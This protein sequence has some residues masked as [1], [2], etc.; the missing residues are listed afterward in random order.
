MT[1]KLCILATASLLALAIPAIGFLQDPN[2]VVKACIK[3]SDRIDGSQSGSAPARCRCFD[4]ASRRF[5]DD[6]NYA[7]LEAASRRVVDCFTNTNVEISTWNTN[8][9]PMDVLNVAS[10]SADFLLLAQKIPRVCK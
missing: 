7:M 5:L 8:V 2:P 3:L 10:S 6:R 4:Q 9:Q 1:G